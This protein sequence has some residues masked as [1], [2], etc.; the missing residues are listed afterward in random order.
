MHAG[1]YRVDFMPWARDDYTTPGFHGRDEALIT[2]VNAGR[3]AGAYQ[4]NFNSVFG[5]GKDLRSDTKVSGYDN[6]SDSD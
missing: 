3:L 2:D 6:D 4:H 1:R 5:R